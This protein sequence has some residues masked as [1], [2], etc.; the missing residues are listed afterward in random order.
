MLPYDEIMIISALYSTNTISWIV[1]ASWNNI[2][3]V[4][5]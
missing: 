1:L 3:R 5:M 2:S 4:D